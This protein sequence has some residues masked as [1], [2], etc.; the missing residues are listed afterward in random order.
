[1]DEAVE[2][3]GDR[4]PFEVGAER[5]AAGLRGF[6]ANSRQRCRKRWTARNA[7]PPRC[8]AR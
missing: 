3:I 1:M 6:C 7:A 8:P 2:W 5:V 4:L